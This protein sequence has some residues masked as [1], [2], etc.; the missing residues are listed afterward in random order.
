MLDNQKYENVKNGHVKK[1]LPYPTVFLLG[2]RF[3]PVTRYGSHTESENEK[4]YISLW[5]IFV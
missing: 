3:F 1:S 2:N 5:N 4:I